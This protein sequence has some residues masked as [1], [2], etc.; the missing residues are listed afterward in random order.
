MHTQSLGQIAFNAYFNAYFN[1]AT[2]YN[3][4]HCPDSVQRRWE[5]VAAAVI[6]HNDPY[7]ELRAAAAAGKT[8]QIKGHDDIWSDLEWYPAFKSAVDNYRIKP[9]ELSRQLPGFRALHESEEWNADGWTESDLPSGYRPALVGECGRVEYQSFGNIWVET[10]PGADSRP[11]HC[12]SKYRTNRP[13]P[14]TTQVPTILDRV[15]AAIAELESIKVAILA[16]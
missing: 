12:L 14:D 1:P 5:E 9:W 2:G 11:V 3:W 7:A 10:D 4:E 8:I 13:L 6:K 15:D 16:K